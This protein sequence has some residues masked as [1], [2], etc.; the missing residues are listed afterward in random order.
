MTK[1]GVHQVEMG[2]SAEMQTYYQSQ[3][4][5]TIRSQDAICPSKPNKIKKTIPKIRITLW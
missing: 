4:R 3:G 2:F 1:T 5:I